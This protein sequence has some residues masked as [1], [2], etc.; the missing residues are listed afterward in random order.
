[1]FQLS[2]TRFRLATPLPRRTRLA[3]DVVLAC[4][5]FWGTTAVYRSSTGHVQNCDS[6]YSLVVAEKIL[7]ERT[8]DLRACIPTDPSIRQAMMGYAPGHDLPYQLIR[9]S[10]PRRPADPSAICYGYPLGST[11]LSLPLVDHY[12]LRRGLST[13]HPDGRPNTAIENVLQLQIA[14]RVA[15]AAVVLFYVLARFFCPPVAAVLIAAGFAFGS[16]VWSTLSRALWS[17]T[18]MVFCLTAAVV[19]LVARRRVEQATWK[20]DLL[21]GIALG[22]LSFWVLFVRA[23]GVFSIAAIGAYL[24]LHHRRLLLVT[25]VVGGLWSAALLAVSLSVFGT[26]T[27]PS[28]Y[29]AGAIDGRDVL[30][31]L[32]WLMASPSRGLLVYCPYVAVAA[33]MLLGYRRHLTDA[34]LLLPAGLALA[35]HTALFSCY[36]GWHGG[37]SYGPRYFCDVIPWLVLATAIAVRGWTNALAPGPSWRAT[38]T[39]IALAACFGWGVFVH[40]RGAN[41]IKA[42]IWNARSLAVGQEAS[43][44]EWRHPQFLTGL[45]FDVNLDGSVTERR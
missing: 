25:I 4:L 17:H 20:T 30:N 36:N 32:A 21:F 8:V 37:S 33:A 5:L 14:G 12:G 13:L 24:L 7:T 40:S 28:V 38:L 27:P 11:L 1:M 31:R 18:W 35:A 16:P 45:T 22:T 19:V 41:S 29:D 2:L 9:H 44:K 10:N 3:L 15:A 39:P 43:V 34:G 26:P 42:W 23:H 6:V